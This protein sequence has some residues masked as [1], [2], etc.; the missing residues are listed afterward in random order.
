MIKNRNERTVT[1]KIS[2]FELCDMLMALTALDEQYESRTRFKDLHDKLRSQLDD[3]DK[4]LDN[5]NY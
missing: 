5:E 3:F 4:K 1:V 2:R